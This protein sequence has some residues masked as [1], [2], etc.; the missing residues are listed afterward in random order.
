M[1]MRTFNV[2]LEIQHGSGRLV[3]VYNTKDRGAPAT[4]PIGDDQREWKMKDIII[5]AVDTGSLSRA[6][7]C[8][9]NQCGVTINNMLYCFN[10]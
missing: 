10:C 3:G 8:A 5:D 9:Q 7:T 1:A 6:G 4:T 2:T